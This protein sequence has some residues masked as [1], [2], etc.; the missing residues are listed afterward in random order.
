MG[1]G[2][3]VSN[4]VFTEGSGVQISIRLYSSTEVTVNN[5]GSGSSCIRVLGTNLDCDFALPF[6]GYDRTGGI[7]HGHLT[8]HLGRL[9]TVRVRNIVGHGVLANF[10]LINRVDYGGLKVGI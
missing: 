6:Q 4:G 10:I 1:I 3:I 9:I 2:D 7:H 5:I 8:S